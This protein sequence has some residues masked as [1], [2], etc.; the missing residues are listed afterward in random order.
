M[1]S[2]SAH[3]FGKSISPDC[4]LSSSERSVTLGPTESTHV[5]GIFEA[6]N[7]VTVQELVKQDI[8]WT[9]GI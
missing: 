7:L 3:H 5:F 4:S 2:I 8:Y 6:E 1:L 9:E